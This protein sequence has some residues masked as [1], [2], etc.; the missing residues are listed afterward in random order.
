MER[1]SGAVFSRERYD[2]VIFDLDGVI[3]S[4]ARVHASAWKR[5]F[6]EYF[7][8]RR[9][10][11][12]ET[13]EPFD[14]EGDYYRYVDGKPRY[15]GV[16]SLLRSRGVELPY[17]SPE[18]PPGK[19]T[20]CGLGNRKNRYF[21]DRLKRQGVDVYETSVDL[22][23]ELRESGFQVSVVSS[24]KNC[25]SVLE[26]AG[27]TELFDQKV[28]GV[29]SEQMGLEGKPAPDTF[30]EAAGR[31]GVDPGRSVVVEDSIA[32]VKAGRRGNFGC[33][34][35]VDRTDNPSAY[36]ENGAD[37]VV[38]DLGEVTVASTERGS[39]ANRTLPSALGKTDQIIA[40]AEGKRLAVFLDY[41]GTL[42]PIVETPEQAVLSDAM[43][44]A[45]E[46][47]ADAYPVAVISGRDLPDVKKLVGLDDIYYA[48]SHGFDI[49]GPQGRRWE[50]GKAEGCLPALD[51]AENE[52]RERLSRIPGALV[53]RKK[54]SIAVHYRKVD[55]ERVEAVER[56][57]SDVQQSHQE[58]RKSYGKKVYELQPGIEWDKGKALVWLLEEL[59]LDISR[60]MPIYLGD[61]V[62]DEDA[63]KALRG[64]G[65]GIVVT[66]RARST[67]AEYYLR[68][69]EEV[70]EFLRTLVSPGKGVDG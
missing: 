61:D 53:E 49:A 39:S 19:E 28:D 31:L 57:V 51:L 56:A 48:G 11:S 20:I 30:L 68:S 25:A 13:L 41:D 15:D 40:R 1:G 7:E 17:G 54:F 23:R 44:N 47:L 32:G 18:D 52:L 21:Q 59:D 2:A 10:E 69:P 8:E 66:E 42:T 55:P 24:S 4:T 45:L 6:D 3:T 46:N 9:S 70:R 36:L 26:S 5:L 16:K 29:D 34:V 22:V 67:A 50:A 58:L 14:P 12:G 27:I 63:F 33:V 43:R 35:G 64:K 37:I 60:V 38:R 65:V 62:T